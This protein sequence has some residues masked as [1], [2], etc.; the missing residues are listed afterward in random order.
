ML[1]GGRDQVVHV[2]DAARKYKLLKTVP[3]FEV[4]EGLQVVSTEH[5]SSGATTLEV[6]TAGSRGHLRVWDCTVGSRGVEFTLD[7]DVM[8]GALLGASAGAQ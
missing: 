7:R 6:V 1:S 3:V 4:L 2:W 5:G 8:I